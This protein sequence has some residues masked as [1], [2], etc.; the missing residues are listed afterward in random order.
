MDVIMSNEKISAEVAPVVPAVHGQ[1]AVAEASKPAKDVKVV[2]LSIDD[3][4][5]FGGDPKWFL[6]RLYPVLQKCRRL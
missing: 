2:S 3:N 5:D 6:G 1:A 4:D